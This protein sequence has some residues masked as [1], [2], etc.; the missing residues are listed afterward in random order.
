MSTGI[1]NAKIESVSLEINLDSP[2]EELVIKLQIHSRIGTVCVTFPYEKMPKL[3]RV[4]DIHDYQHIVGSPCQVLIVD[5]I[6]RDLGNFMFYHYDFIS[7]DK[8]KDKWVLG[9]EY[10]KQV[11]DYKE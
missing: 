10:R 9:S 3:L 1:Y 11:L 6:F 7:F 4:L 2:V 5:D 8:E